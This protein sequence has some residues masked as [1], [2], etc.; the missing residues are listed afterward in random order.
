M[1]RWARHCWLLYAL[2]VLAAPGA[3]HHDGP[4]F[5]AALAAAHD[6]G[7]PRP[8]VTDDAARVAHAADGV[9]LACQLLSQAAV[10]PVAPPALADPGRPHLS[11]RDPARVALPADRRPP[12]R[13]PPAA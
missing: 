2:A 6:A 13:A 11:D 1:S 3:H 12:A 7:D 10:S 9:C 4:E 8:H 5:G